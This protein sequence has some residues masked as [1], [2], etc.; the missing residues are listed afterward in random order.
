MPRAE[1]LRSAGAED[2]GR[3][4]AEKLRTFDAGDMRDVTAEE[5][6][7]LCE[8]PGDKGCADQLRSAVQN[9][10]LLKSTDFLKES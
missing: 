5:L 2:L 7:E 6:E 3:T 4:A 10:Q 1:E 8:A 9:G